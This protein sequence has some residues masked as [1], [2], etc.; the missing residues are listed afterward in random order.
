MA[1]DRSKQTQQQ[2]NYREGN[3]R[4]FALAGGVLASVLTCWSGGAFGA[5]MPK[6]LRGN[7]CSTDDSHSKYVKC[8]EP[9]LSITRKGSGIEEASCAPLSV[10]KQPNDIWIVK[11]RCT[12]EGLMEPSDA[13]I[14]Y[15]RVG[16]YLFVKACEENCPVQPGC[17]VNAGGTIFCPL[18]LLQ[19]AKP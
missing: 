6:E 4:H 9:E 1:E 15:A 14:Q 11:E 17:R 18:E 3:P 16:N 10:S 7:W 8:N 19:R 13:T 5:E 12:V 2:A